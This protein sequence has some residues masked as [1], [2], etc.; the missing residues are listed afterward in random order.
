MRVKRDDETISG[1]PE[2]VC[3]EGVASLQTVE[4]ARRGP[5]IAGL[6][7]PAQGPHS[8]AALKVLA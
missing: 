6:L 5:A 4:A 8:G 7:W 2:H 3:D 1:G